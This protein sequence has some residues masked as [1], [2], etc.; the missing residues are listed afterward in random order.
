MRR[1]RVKERQPGEH[2]APALGPLKALASYPDPTSDGN[3]FTHINNYFGQGVNQSHG[4]QMD[5][6]IDHIISDRQRI[7]W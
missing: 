4:N 3:T 6:K 1:Y 2:F 7:M 5:T